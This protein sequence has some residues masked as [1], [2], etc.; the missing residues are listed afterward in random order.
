MDIQIAWN[1]GQQSYFMTLYVNGFNQ[2]IIY[3]KTQM[4]I[5]HLINI[6]KP[7]FPVTVSWHFSINQTMKDEI[8]AL[9]I[10]HT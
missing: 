8:T 2:V 10:K 5:I 1:Q 4:Q 6:L 3:T 9:I 7:A